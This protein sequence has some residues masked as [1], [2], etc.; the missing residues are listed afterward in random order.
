MAVDIV[1]MFVLLIVFVITLTGLYRI[2]QADNRRVI[3]PST[4]RN[5]PEHVSEGALARSRR[6]GG[7]RRDRSETSTVAESLGGGGNVIGAGVEETEVSE[8]EATALEA[9]LE[10]EGAKRGSVQISLMWDN[11]NDLDLHVI[12]PSGEHVYHD[13]RKSKCG[14]ELD[15]DMNF[16]PTS[17]TPVENVVWTE[18]PPPGV[19]RVGIRH[20]KIHKRGFLSKIPLISMLTTTNETHFKLGVT[21]GKSKK[22]YEG[23]IERGNDV[24][25]VAKFAIAEASSEQGGVAAAPV[26]M[27]E[28][29][30]TEAKEIETLRRRI[31]TVRDGVSVSLG[32]DSNT[33]LGLSIVNSEG[34]EVSFFNPESMGGSFDIEG[35]NPDSGR[36]EIIWASDPPEGSYTV[37]VQHFET[38]EQEESTDFTVTIDNKGEEQAFEG[39]ISS[40][41]S[42][43]E[44]GSFD[45]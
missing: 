36:Q 24:K 23:T 40:D 34:E 6:S 44:A 2:F 43:F 12:T 42:R 38:E 10:R 30:F 16:K 22:F 8:S 13:N 37:I 5:L 20:F 11:W 21:I 45:I 18:T 41:G 4:R 15:I 27:E 31:G 35:Y 7:S 33:D 25:F 19:Y 26:P 29:E 32:W 17:K 9:R 28:E 39:T 14:G 1:S 3:L